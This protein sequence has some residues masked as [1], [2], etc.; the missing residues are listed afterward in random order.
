MIPITLQLTDQVQVLR[1]AFYDGTNGTELVS[2]FGGTVISDTGSLLTYQSQGEE[3]ACPVGQR[4][5]WSSPDASNGYGPDLVPFPW[6]VLPAPVTGSGATYALITV[7]G[8]GSVPAS[9]LGAV[10]TVDV[11]L[12]PVA[13]GE[14]RTLSDTVYTPI[15]T[16]RGAPN[17]V[18]GH[19][20]SNLIPPLPLSATSTRVTV[21]SGAASLAGG[22]VHVVAQQVRAV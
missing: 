15:V 8:T 18:S 6:K 2:Q 11:T 16:L 7:T 10:Q 4:I 9:L 13:G 1:S 14:G 12:A 21:I 22:I 5:F 17:V 19:S 20:V 3:Y